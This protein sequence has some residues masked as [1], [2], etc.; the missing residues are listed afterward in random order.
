MVN[1]GRIRGH[2]KLE[3]PQFSG[4]GVHVDIGLQW[5]DKFFTQ[6]F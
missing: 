6:I 1:E 2:G 4:R 5:R 3:V